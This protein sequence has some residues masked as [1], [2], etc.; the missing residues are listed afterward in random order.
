MDSPAFVANARIGAEVKFSRKTR[1]PAIAEIRKNQASVAL[2]KLWAGRR[3]SPRRLTHTQIMGLA[4][5]V[6]ELYVEEFQQEPG[7][8]AAWIA[9]KALTRAVQEG[10]LIGALSTSLPLFPGKCPM[11]ACLKKRVRPSGSVHR[12]AGRIS[13]ST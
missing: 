11:K 9:H 13:G 3:S 5:L 10:R 7:D 2:A 4:R 12:I 8:R 6:H 1:D